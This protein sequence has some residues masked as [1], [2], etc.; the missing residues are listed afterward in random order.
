[1]D[2][3]YILLD[4]LSRAN[5]RYFYLEAG[6][7]VQLQSQNLINVDSCEISRHSCK[8]PKIYLDKLWLHLT[9]APC[10]SSRIHL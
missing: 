4:Y 8:L 5:D 7:I 1:M 9:H 3:Q 2:T 6:V 10:Y